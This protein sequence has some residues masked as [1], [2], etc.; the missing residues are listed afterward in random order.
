MRPIDGRSIATSTQNV[1][2][3][4]FELCLNL[5]VVKPRILEQYYWP[6]PREGET[7]NSMRPWTEGSVEI[8]GVYTL[9]SRMFAADSSQFYGSPGC[10]ICLLGET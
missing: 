4:S 6:K 8:E 5:S 2:L 9:W 10:L 3:A 7:A 1:I